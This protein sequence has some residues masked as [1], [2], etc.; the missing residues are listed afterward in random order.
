[1]LHLYLHSQVVWSETS[2]SYKADLVPTQ[3]NM[4][5]L[6][7]KVFYFILKTELDRKSGYVILVTCVV[8]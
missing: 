7:H 8:V 5:A 3:C 6:I 1:V 4:F 2:E